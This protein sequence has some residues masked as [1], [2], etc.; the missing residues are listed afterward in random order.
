MGGSAA[1]VD[2][3]AVGM[4]PDDDRLEPQAGQQRRRDSRRR[5]VRAV[6]RQ[7]ETAGSERTCLASQRV[8]FRKHRAQVI[9]IGPDEIRLRNAGRL[10]VSCPPRRV[11]DDRLDLALHAL[12]KLRTSARKHLDAVVLERVVRSGDH[13]A[14]LVAR[15]PREVGDGRRRHDA[16]ARHARAFSTRSVRKLPFDPDARLARITANQQPRRGRSGAARQ[17]AH[18]RRP[19]T[20]NRRRVERVRAGRAADTVGAKESRDL[21][22]ARVFRFAF[23]FGHC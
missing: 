20:A 16:G 3:P 5:A 12:G 14:S 13:D 17:G 19:D 21:D 9:E 1:Q 22:G 11:G 7:S 6:D 4:V 18:Q 15:R 8:R 10:A 23:S 2:V